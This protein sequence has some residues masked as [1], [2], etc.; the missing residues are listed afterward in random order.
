MTE[1]ST[2]DKTL[3]VMEQVIDEKDAEIGIWKSMAKR[4]QM[5]LGLI[6]LT[7]AVTA[8][9]LLYTMAREDA[10]SYTNGDL[11]YPFIFASGLIIFV[12]CI[13]HFSLIVTTIY[14]DEI[15]EYNDRLTVKWQALKTRITTR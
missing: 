2:E 10:L 7:V 15:D 3:K 13:H 14:R 5:I 12:D 4:Y 8:W 11:I 6:W 1:L 9:Y